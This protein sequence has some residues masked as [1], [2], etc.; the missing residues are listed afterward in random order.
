VAER[1]KT[2]AVPE[3]TLVSGFVIEATATS[4]GDGRFRRARFQLAG[5]LFSPAGESARRAARVWYVNAAWAIADPH[6]MPN[7]GP[8]GLYVASGRLQAVLDFNPLDHPGMVNASLFLTSAPPAGGRMVGEGTFSG[9]ER[10]EGML[11]WKLLE[12]CEPVAKIARRMPA[13][14][15]CLRPGTRAQAI[16]LDGQDAVGGRTR[17]LKVPVVAKTPPGTP[18]PGLPR[19]Y[20][21]G[22]RPR[23]FPVQ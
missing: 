23:P 8:E 22:Q 2:V 5:T 13:L 17:A 15:A 10:F 3:G 4:I 9:N 21:E 19:S 18:D 6:P 14:D 16:S 1:G 7:E 11:S 20:G 12:R